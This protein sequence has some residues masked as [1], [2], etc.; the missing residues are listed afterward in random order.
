MKKVVNPLF[1]GLVDDLGREVLTKMSYQD[2]P[3][4]SLVCKA[5]NDEITSH[6]FSRFRKAA[7]MARP[8][9][10]LA[11]AQ[12]DDKKSNLDR[13]SLGKLNPA[14]PRYRLV[15]FDPETQDWTRLPEIPGMSGGLP[16]FCGLVGFGFGWDILIIGGLDPVTWQTSNDVYIYSFLS[17]KWRKSADMAG[18]RRSFFG[19]ATSDDDRTVVVAGGHDEDKNALKSAILYD[20]DKDEW[21]PLPDMAVTR[22]ECKVI[23]HRGKFHVISGYPTDSQGCFNR[24]AEVFDKSTWR[25]GPVIENFLGPSA[26]PSSCVAGLDGRVYACVGRRSGEVAV[27]LGD[28]GQVISRIPADVSSSHSIVVC[29]KDKLLVIGSSKIGEGNKGYMLDLKSYI[30]TQIDVP[31]EFCGHVQSSC[32]LEI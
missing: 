24:T 22:D 30:W 11:Q 16:M 9:V 19:C 25:W 26:S 1:P 29:E 5:W 21:T 23:F 28:K 17:G 6:D 12:I 3:T 10:I 32:V 14:R 31:M 27:R 4:A 18:V 15:L 8:I 13:C 7:S 20:V 2:L